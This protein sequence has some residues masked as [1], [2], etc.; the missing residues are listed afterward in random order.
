M[1]SGLF[2]IGANAFIDEKQIPILLR[3]TKIQATVQII[4]TC[5]CIFKIKFV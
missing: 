2:K 1:S 5:F 3:I 4:I